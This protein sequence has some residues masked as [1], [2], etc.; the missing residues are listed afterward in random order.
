M[1][2]ILFPAS[3][4]KPQEHFNNTVRNHKTIDEIHNFLHKKEIEELYSIYPDGKIYLWGSTNARNNIAQYNKVLDGDMALFFRPGEMFSYVKILKKIYNEKLAEYLWGTKSKTNDTTW[5][6]IYFL[7]KPIFKNISYKEFTGSLKI[8]RNGVYDKN[9]NFSRVLKFRVIES[10]NPIYHSSKIIEFVKGVSIELIVLGGDTPEPNSGI[11]KEDLKQQSEEC[12]RVGRKGEEFLN[13][14]FINQ[15]NIKNIK[16]FVWENEVEESFKPYD[17]VITDFDNKKIFVD[18]KSTVNKF[19]IPFFMSQKEIRKSSECD[20]YIYRIF[21]IDNN[22]KFRICKNI[23][24][25]TQKLYNEI[26]TFHRS[27]KAIDTECNNIAFKIIPDS[28]KL[29]FSEENTF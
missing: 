22:P 3:S 15:K 21:D 24:D 28:K 19:S 4:K 14:Y 2:V 8:H 25:I 16:N 10:S 5:E 1:N 6:Y 7:S 23:K 20:Y 17:F 26:I 9:G 29:I 27:I 18:A 13:T 12:E 11:T